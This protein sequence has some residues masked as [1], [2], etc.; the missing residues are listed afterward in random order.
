MWWPTTI[1]VVSRIWRHLLRHQPPLHHNP[2]FS[3]ALTKQLFVNNWWHIY[4]I[5]DRWNVE[6]AAVWGRGIRFVCEVFVD[7]TRVARRKRPVVA[8]SFVWALVDELINCNWLIW[9]NQSRVCVVAHVVL[10]SIVCVY[11]HGAYDWFK[12]WRSIGNY[13]ICAYRPIA[14]I[15]VKHARASRR[16]VMLQ[17]GLCCPAHS[18]HQIVPTHRWR[19]IL[20]WL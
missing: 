10:S 6:I 8:L 5:T 4:L 14:F 11:L 20:E 3:V 19:M 7:G 16:W 1:S 2:M 15:Y 18:A 9:I 13:H 17:T 12:R